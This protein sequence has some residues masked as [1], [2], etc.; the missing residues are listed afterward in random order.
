MWVCR[1]M[2]AHGCGSQKVNSVVLWN[3]STSFKKAF[4][5]PE[6]HLLREDLLGSEPQESS[7]LHTFSVG[8]TFFFFA[9]L[10]CGWVG[11]SNSVHC[12]Y[13]VSVLH[14]KP[15]TQNNS[16]LFWEAAS[17]EHEKLH[18]DG[19]L[20]YLMTWTRVCGAPWVSFL[21]QQAL[22]WQDYYCSKYEFPSQVSSHAR[23][24]FFLSEFYA[25]IQIL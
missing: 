16:N 18:V 2:C 7:C 25:K 14:S 19:Y 4:R 10:L 3:T 23:L 22:K 17:F 13:K 24:I 8:I 21:T 5:W 12:T 9:V 1:C 11:E 6:A 20:S 15:S